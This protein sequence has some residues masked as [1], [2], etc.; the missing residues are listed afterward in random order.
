MDRARFEHLLDAYGADFRGWPERERSGG[1]AFA[2][3][4]EQ[5]LAAL[6]SA[7]RVRALMDGRFNAAFDDVRALALPC[8]CHRVA[9]GF[10]GV[11]DGETVDGL[12][13]SI[14]DDV[15]PC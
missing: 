6:I 7:A 12:I 1:E 8:L 14:L 2:R 15:K 3:A 13:R 5:E 10:E 4:H 9:L 11:A